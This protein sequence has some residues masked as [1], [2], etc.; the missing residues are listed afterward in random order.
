VRENEKGVS[1]PLLLLIF[2]QSKGTLKEWPK[3]T[4]VQGDRAGA[5]PLE[6]CRLEKQ[7]T[8]AYFS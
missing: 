2:I 4:S 6:K 3:A 5:R 8:T 1:Y 7:S